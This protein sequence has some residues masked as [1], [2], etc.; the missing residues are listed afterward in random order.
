MAHPLAQVR[1][2]LKPTLFN[3][4]N[5]QKPAQIEAEFARIAEPWV[6]CFSKASRKVHGWACTAYDCF[7][8]GLWDGHSGWLS[9]GVGW[10]DRLSD[11]TAYSPWSLA[12]ASEPRV[13]IN[14]I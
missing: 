1:R 4:L 7:R 14:G 8:F 5:L 2:P 10:K 13:L 11:S 3:P 9:I 12:A 6:N